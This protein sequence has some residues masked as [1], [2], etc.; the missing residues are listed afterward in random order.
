[1]KTFLKES[2][3]AERPAS[4]SVLALARVL[5]VSVSRPLSPSPP[6]PAPLG[7]QPRLARNWRQ[8]HWFL[9]CKPVFKQS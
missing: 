5:S 9:A 1:M 7:P 6:L 8:F 4:V 3:F 2:M